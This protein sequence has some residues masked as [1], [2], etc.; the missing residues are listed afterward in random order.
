MNN[1][2]NDLPHGY[3]PADA[4]GRGMTKAEHVDSHL[5][6]KTDKHRALNEYAHGGKIPPI[7]DRP[8]PAKSFDHGRE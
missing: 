3:T 8:A 5:K 7:A 2:D 1:T 6:Y 4:F